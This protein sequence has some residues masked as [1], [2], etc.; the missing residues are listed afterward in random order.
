M[1]P[2][3]EMILASSGMT[4]LIFVFGGLLVVAIL[5][6]TALGKLALPPLVGYLLLGLG[7]RI[8]ESRVNL[9]GQVGHEILDFL[10]QLGLAVLLFRVGLESNL[11]GLLKQLRRA[12]L[13]WLA[14]V[15][16]SALAGFVA[17]RYLLGAGLVPS[18]L[19]A[20][21]MTATS[22]GVPTRLWRQRKALDSRDGELFLDVAELDDLSGVIFLGLLFAVLPALEEAGQ[23]IAV[24]D[25]AG[26]VGIELAGFAGRFVLLAGLCYLF[27]RF[28]EARMTNFL[29]RVDEPPEPMLVVAGV[30]FLVAAL[31]GLLGFSVAIGAF[32]A[33]LVFSGDPHRVRVD[34]NFDSL[35]ELFGPFF[36][37]TIG[38]AMDPASLSAGLIAGA[39]LLGAAVAGKLLG[40]SG[41][42]WPMLGPAPAATIGVS[43]I[44]RAEI[45]LIIM[46]R[47]RELGADVLPEK[48]YNG[49]IVVCAATCLVAPALLRRL[50]DRFGPADASG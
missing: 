33:G 9:L 39:I 48:I 12:S 28:V 1:E 27:S 35:Y 31:A 36:F 20:V 13:V 3:E 10:G 38:L 2:I 26:T 46:Q 34:A 5:I 43:M 18:V 21:A 11:P 44:P 47:G 37:I 6:K 49:M 29:C 22:V 45:T 24:A 19:V 25:L 23:G 50:L 30:G 17:A 15:V 41:P 14:N 4:T 16:A 8:L 42:I 40:T 7:L 32:L